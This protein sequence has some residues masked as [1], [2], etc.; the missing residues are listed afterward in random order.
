MNRK[1]KG[2]NKNVAIAKSRQWLD[3]PEEIWENILNRLGAIEILENAQKVCTMWRRVFKDPFMWRIIDISNCRG[4]SDSNHFQKICSH[5][6]DRSQGELVD[7]RL[8]FF[9]TKESLAYVAER[10]RKLKRLRIAWCH[11]KLVPEVFVEVFQKLPLLEELSLTDTAITIKGIEAL[12]RFCPRLKSFELKNVSYDIKSIDK[13]NDEA[14]AIAK[15]LPALH[16]LQLIGNS[17]TNV[18]L[19]AI[20]DGCP[21]LV[22]LDLRGCFNVRLDKVLS[23]RISQQIKDVKYP[24]DSLASHN[25]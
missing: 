2:R 18:G 6:V 12:G 21:I 22:S 3:L 19:R 8:A 4:L 7:I 17:M 1:A 23:S 16:H 9:A 13:P 14:L 15:N 25:F 10:S 20:L 24:R 11:S 5:A